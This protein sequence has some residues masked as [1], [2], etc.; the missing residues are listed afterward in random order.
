M[1]RL[2]RKQIWQDILLLDVSTDNHTYSQT[3]SIA[4]RWKDAIIFLPNK[5]QNKLP[6]SVLNNVAARKRDTEFSF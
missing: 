4:D 6:T 1:E 2:L 5:T 3:T